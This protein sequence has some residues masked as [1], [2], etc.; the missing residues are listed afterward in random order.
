MTE[1]VVRLPRLHGGQVEVRDGAARYNVLMCGRRWGKTVFGVERIADAALRGQSTAWFAPTY[2]YLAEVW[3]ELVRR[4][5]PVIVESNKTER[6]IELSTGGV[7]EC[8]TLDD[9]DAARGRAYHLVIIDEA[10][11][12]R[13][14]GEAWQAAIRPALADYQGAAWFLSTPRGRDFF[15]SLFVRGQQGDNGWKSWRMPTS[16]NP[17]IDDGEIEAAR[18]ELP[19]H[20]YEQEFEAV[21]ADQQSSPF[22]LDNIRRAMRD[23]PTSG[24]PVCYGV[25]LAK[26]SDHTVIVGLDSDGN[27]CHFERF[28]KPWGETEERIAQVVK[29]HA[30]VDS[31]GVGDPIVEGLMRRGLPV[32]GFKFTATSKQQIM[33]H[34]ASL[35]HKG[36][37]AVYGDVMQSELEAFEYEY[38]PGGVRYSAPNGLHDDC[39]CALALACELGRRMGLYLPRR[40]DKHEPISHTSRLSRLASFA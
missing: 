35:L 31:T 16:T 15:H 30:L 39:V 29:V 7:I 36:K 40:F 33:E 4:L 20:I 38:R 12:V 2:K 18:L 8:W 28:Q 10:A 34:L 32:E 14:L 17:H 26:S 24:R 27:M 9:P 13:D 3:R 37:V 23:G 11:K 21:P 5:R 1:A 6:R 22:G 25:D 19:S